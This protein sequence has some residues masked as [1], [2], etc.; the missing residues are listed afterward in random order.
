MTAGRLLLPFCPP[1]LIYPKETKFT[2]HLKEM[3]KSQ[4]DE[5]NPLIPSTLQEMKDMLALVCH[6]AP[7]IP[8]QVQKENP[9]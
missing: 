8:Q 3:E 1:G 5:P 4:V 7:Y 2:S 6:N 9:D